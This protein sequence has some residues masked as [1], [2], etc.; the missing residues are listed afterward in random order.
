MRAYRHVAIV[1]KWLD[2]DEAAAVVTWDDIR[3][4][5]EK[6]MGPNHYVTIR[7]REAVERHGGGDPDIPNYDCILPF[8]AMR[9]KCRRSGTEIQVGH[10]GGETNLLSRDLLY[11]ENKLWRWRNPKTNR[12]VIKPGNW[13]DGTRW[14]E[15]VESKH[16]FRG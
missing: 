16:C 13:L 8:N 5:A 4:L 7:L 3:G 12:G 14:L 11:A 2:L 10:T 1:P 15:I 6:L 9:E